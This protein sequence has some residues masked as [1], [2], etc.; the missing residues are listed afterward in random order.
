[1]PRLVKKYLCDFR[2]GT[3]AMPSIERAVEHEAV[4][5]RNPERRTCDTCKFYE[6]VEDHDYA[7][8]PYPMLWN[9]HCYHKCK[10]PDFDGFSHLPEESFEEKR[11]LPTKAIFCHKW[12]GGE[13]PI[14]LE[15]K[16]MDRSPKEIESDT[17]DGDKLP[18]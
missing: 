17:S 12:N 10:H 5:R 11:L 1:M 4:C 7:D 9:Y 3:N 15:I 18:F 8:D 14:D 16:P 6:L 2:C 13:Y